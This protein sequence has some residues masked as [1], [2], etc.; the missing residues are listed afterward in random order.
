MNCRTHNWKNVPI[1]VG[2]EKRR[3]PGLYFTRRYD[4]VAEIAEKNLK[5]ILNSD[6]LI[7]KSQRLE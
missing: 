2:F 6:M 1:Y 4:D 7:A 5:G 3:A